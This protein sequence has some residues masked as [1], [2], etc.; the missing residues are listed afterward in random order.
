MFYSQTQCRIAPNLFTALAAKGKLT[1]LST[2]LNIQL[3]GDFRIHGNDA[4]LAEFNSPRLQ[5]LLAYL[6][7]RRG[8][9]QT[10]QH[11]A[12]LFWPD[13]GDS[14]ARTNLRNALHQLRN[15]LPEAERCLQIDSQ[16][17]T[18][19]S[20][21][22]YSVDLVDF[23]KL[24]EQADKAQHLPEQRQLL[25]QALLLYRGDLLPDCYEEWILPEREEWRRKYG[26]VLER[27]VDV[28]ERQRDY[29][30]AIEACQRLLKFDPLQES[31]YTQLMRLHALNGDRAS[32]LRVYHNCMTTLVN[33]LGV[34]PGPTTQ[35]VYEQLLNLEATSVQS[36]SSPVVPGAGAAALLPIAPSLVGRDGVWQQLQEIWR[37]AA[38]GSPTLTILSAEAGLGKTRLAAELTEWASRQ[39][40]A[41]ATTHCYASGGRLAF[42]PIV[43]WLR[44]PVMV[45]ARRKL[46][47]AWFAEA[48]RLLPELLQEHPELQPPVAVAPQTESWHRQQLF[49]ALARLMLAERQPLLLVLDDAHWCDADTIEWLHYLFHTN[50]QTPLLLLATLRPE[51]ITVD[52]PFSELQRQLARTGR[53]YQIEL[54]P[55]TP[56][57]TAQLAGQLTSNLATSALDEATNSRI[58]EETEGNPLFILETVRSA[59][60]DERRT[61]Q[62]HVQ[63]HKGAES[64]AHVILPPKIRAIMEA[65]LTRLSPAARDLVAIAALIGRAFTLDVLSRVAEL[66]EDELLL[67]LDELWQQ[68]IIREAETNETG[69]DAYDFSHDKLREVASSALSPMIRR[70]L[71]R[72]IGGA[73]EEIHVNSMEWAAAQI[74][75]HFEQARQDQQAIYYYQLAATLDHRRSAQREAILHLQRALGLLEKLP[76]DENRDAQ[77]LKMQ[78]GLGAMLLATRGYADAAVENAFTRALTLCRHSQDPTVRVQT[79]WGLARFYLVKSELEKGQTAAQELLGLAHH[80]EDAGLILEATYAMGTYC[81]HYGSLSEA[82][83]YL[84]QTLML[85]D[86]GQHAH[87]ALQYAQDP[88]VVALTYLALAL[89]CQGYLDQAR[90]R[91]QEAITVAREISHPYSLVVA[92][93]F[94][95]VLHQ[96]ADDTVRCAQVAEEAHELAKTYGFSLWV[97][98]AGF[99]RGWA[100]AQQADPR[101]GM[102]LMMQHA[103]GFRTTG[104]ELGSAYST[105]MLAQSVSRAGQAATA[106]AMMQQSFALIHKTQERLCAADIYRIQGELLLSSAEVD[107]TQLEQARLH[108][109]SALSIAQQ[110][111]AR[112]WELRAA[113]SQFH[114]AQQ[115]GGVE[116]AHQRLQQVVAWFTE[117]QEEPL[118]QYAQSLLK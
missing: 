109:D 108:I 53:V 23:A 76:Q 86:R 17:I 35:T 72:R 90:V 82:R 6:V 13:S 47:P 77:E 28:F 2:S 45:Q 117:G 111:S 92:L 103:E 95:G 9:A 10:R 85:F 41:T 78:L 48:T 32:A 70:L 64:P 110:Q 16:S 4:S 21:G 25:E 51:E 12:F 58:Y 59:L 38:G 105:A 74:A 83:R 1:I 66:T 49:E 114:F 36:S 80:A 112:W 75:A 54:A 116:G 115:H 57:E 60:E 43:T 98:M 67:G 37:Q 65:R 62:S 39:A 46:E 5:S 101:E 84:E 30:T 89:W 33:E 87:H 3:L 55:L 44:A 96:F 24:L 50:F 56:S 68:R 106:Q 26:A 100:L 7:L 27:L 61:H 91:S 102:A 29:R 15:A 34:E 94:A 20:D 88:Q 19:R 52:H 99:L 73:L 14:Q 107:S 97:S 40:V 63:R 31:T 118:L 81:L 11:L 22:P 8:I 18:W 42:A 113:L 104:A 79:L 93:T 69:S 71:H